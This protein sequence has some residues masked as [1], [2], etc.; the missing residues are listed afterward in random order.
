MLVANRLAAFFPGLR[1]TKDNSKE[2]EESIH[3]KEQDESC[4]IPRKTKD[5]R[6]ARNFKSMTI[7]RMGKMLKLKSSNFERNEFEL[8]SQE[9]VCDRLK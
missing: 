9:G 7:D 5:E 6:D 3:N 8:T 4:E 2:K 1:H